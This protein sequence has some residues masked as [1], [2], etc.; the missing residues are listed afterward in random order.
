[1]RTYETLLGNV[2]VANEAMTSCYMWPN[3]DKSKRI[4]I[5]K[6]EFE[7]IIKLDQLYRSR[8]V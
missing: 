8:N 4:R 5:K 2:I 3:G 1:M 7:Q 6:R